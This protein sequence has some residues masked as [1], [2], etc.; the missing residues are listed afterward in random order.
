MACQKAITA[1]NV[2]KLLNLGGHIMA[3][4]KKNE[5]RQYWSEEA[6]ELHKLK[7]W[8][9]INFYLAIFALAASIIMPIIRAALA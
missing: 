9:D 3:K 7:V 6:K 1:H 5:Y 4:Q 2:G 8:G